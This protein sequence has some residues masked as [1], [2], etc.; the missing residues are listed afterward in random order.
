[1]LIEQRAIKL[2][3]I[4]A[5]NFETKLRMCVTNIRNGYALEISTKN[6]L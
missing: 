4:N 3:K 1:M 6:M 5:Q 2:M